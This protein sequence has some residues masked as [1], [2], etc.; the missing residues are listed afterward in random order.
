MNF[1]FF[2][3][4]FRKLCEKNEFSLSNL[5]KKISL[6][7][8]YLFWLYAH[9]YPSEWMITKL[10][11]V[12]FTNADEYLMLAFESLFC[13]FISFFF[14]CVK[15]D[16]W[17]LKLMQRFCSD[18]NGERRLLKDSLQLAFT[19]EIFFFSSSINVSILR[20]LK[21]T[22]IDEFPYSLVYPCLLTNK[23]PTDKSGEISGQSHNIKLNIF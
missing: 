5:A 16:Y 1:I 21:F 3:F 10:Y 19:R 14:F 23:T 6:D 8:L 17:I 7:C 13:V 18:I 15:N 12:N 9:H 4:I 2:L 20:S 11:S 22:E